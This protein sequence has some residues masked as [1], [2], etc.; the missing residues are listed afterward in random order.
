MTNHQEAITRLTRW[1]DLMGGRLGGSPDVPD[2][3]FSADVSA[4]L[5]LVT[6]RPISEAPTVIVRWH[7]MWNCEVSVWRNNGC[8]PGGLEWITAT[9]D[10]QWPEEAFLPV[11][12]RPSPAPVTET[13]HD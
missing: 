13:C 8:L 2:E 7:R 6:W 10:H 5:D 1:R 9:K 3:Q 4:L 11:W 12:R